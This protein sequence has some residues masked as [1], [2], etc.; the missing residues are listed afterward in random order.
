MFVSVLLFQHY[1]H[2]QR[3]TVKSVREDKNTQKHVTTGLCTHSYVE[4]IL[5]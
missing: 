5:L 1:L 3:K 2:M 4:Y